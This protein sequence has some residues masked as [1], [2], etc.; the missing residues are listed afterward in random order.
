LISYPTILGA[1]LPVFLVIAAGFWLRRAGRMA[2][3]GDSTL[4]VLTISVTYP[5]YILRSLVD[6]PALRE[7]GNVVP[8][9]VCG[10]GFVLVGLLLGWLIAP[11]CKLQKGTG[12]RTFSLACSVQNYGYLPIPI[13]ETLFPEGAWKG[14]LFVFTLGIEL[15]IWS[16]GVM[17]LSGDWRRGLRQAVNPVTLAVVIG[18]VLNA[19]RVD[20]FIPAW[21]LQFLTMVGACAIPL[22]VL[23]S[24]AMLA[25]LLRQPGSLADPRTFVGAVS[26]RL[27]LLPA[28]MLATARLLPL[29]DTLRQV[30][31]IQAAM[32]AAVFPLIMARRYGGHELTAVRVLVF[33]TVLSFFTIPLVVVIALRLIQ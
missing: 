29:T 22:G 26:L 30:L 9:I 8:P 21:V 27:V 10:G 31:A 14:V 12:R 6:N 7:P 5:C 15:T 2:P 32:P 16:V 11:L 20:A 23:L 19:L 28:V 4:L 18:V 33:T 13:M 25:D 24:G 3:E 1:T 17:I